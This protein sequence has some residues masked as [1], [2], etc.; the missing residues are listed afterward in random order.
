TA[1]HARGLAEVPSTEIGDLV[2]ERLRELNHVAYV[3]FASHYRNFL[4]L[5]DLQ[6]EFERLAVA[7]RR[8]PARA[9][10]AQPPPLPPNELTKLSEPAAPIARRVPAAAEPDTAAADQQQPPVTLEE[11]R[12]RRRAAP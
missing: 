12:A 5:E 7:P 3:R 6:E 1:L 9:G 8:S 2:M 10:A 11:R 4:S